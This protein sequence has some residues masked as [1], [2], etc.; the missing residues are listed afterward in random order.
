MILRA[1]PSESLR[2]D[3]FGQ[4]AGDRHQRISPIQLYQDRTTATTTTSEHKSVSLASNS[5]MACARE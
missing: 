3:R 2:E 1:M 5:T 4:T